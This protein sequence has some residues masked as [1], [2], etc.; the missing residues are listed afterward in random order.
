[1]NKYL[2]PEQRRNATVLNRALIQAQ[3]LVKGGERDTAAI[4]Q[5]AIELIR[6]TPEA[7]IDYVEIVHPETL[8][9]LD[10]IEEKAVMAL[11]VKVGSTRLIDN[12]TLES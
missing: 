11:A 9:C 5:K 1:R 3:E 12:M 8:A 2:S 4:R 6:S 7:E 10:E